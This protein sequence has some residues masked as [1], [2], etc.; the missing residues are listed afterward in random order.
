MSITRIG[1]VQSVA[2]IDS[3]Q[4]RTDPQKRAGEGAPKQ[5]APT[6]AQ[7]AAEERASKETAGGR[8]PLA[9]SKSTGGLKATV[10]LPDIPLRE[11][12]MTLDQDAKRIVI[13]VIDSET[14]DVLRQ[15]PAEETLQLLQELPGVRGLLLDKKG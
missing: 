1:S 7:K 4:R 3:S 8:E 9:P 14:K 12:S 13:K 2:G 15:I 6:T 11:L 10:K 5:A